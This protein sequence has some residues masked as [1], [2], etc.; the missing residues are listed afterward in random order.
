M[1]SNGT[2]PPRTV[3]R[4]TRGGRKQG[5]RK[6]AKHSPGPWAVDSEGYIFLRDCGRPADIA[7]LSDASNVADGRL[8]A[9]APDLLAAAKLGLARIESDIEGSRNWTAEG[10]ALRAAI[11]KAEG[12]Q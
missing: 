12:N 10:D 9:A 1:G 8:I 3:P 2:R 7:V 5:K 11:G 4:G 6:M